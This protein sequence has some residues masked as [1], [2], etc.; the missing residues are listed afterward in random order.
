MS[1]TS[2]NKISILLWLTAVVEAIMIILFPCYNK[3]FRILLNANSSF[4]FP[5]LQYLYSAERLIPLDTCL[6]ELISN[7]TH[8][9]NLLT[10]K[11]DIFNTFNFLV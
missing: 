8:Q 1:L 10:C 2:D 7:S 11:N 5:L 3:A 4:C 9:L 6:F